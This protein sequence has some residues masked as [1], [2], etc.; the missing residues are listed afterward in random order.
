MFKS[1]VYTFAAAGVVAGTPAARSHVARG[2]SA[3]AHPPWPCPETRGSRSVEAGSLAPWEKEMSHGSA[4]KLIL[5]W[6]SMPCCF[7]S[8]MA[9]FRSS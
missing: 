7:S 3:G 6:N 5:L 1:K 4:K 2:L 8:A 9:S